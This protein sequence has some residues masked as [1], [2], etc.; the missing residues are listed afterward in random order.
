MENIA[1]IQIVEPQPERRTAVAAAYRRGYADA[2]EDM[3]KRQREK[4]RRRQYFIMQK[5]NGMSNVYIRSQNR[6]KLYIFGISF[7]SL[8]YEE[9]HDYKRGKEAATHHTICIADGCL[10]EI[11]EYES[12]ERCIEVLDEIEKVCG[13]YL[14]A[15]GSMGLIRGSTPMQPMATVIP[16]VYQMPEK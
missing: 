15:A 6:E 11:A 12:K 10:E 8:Q 4:K 2:L 13:S 7:N 1:R 14:Y 5:L 3:R 9:Q 16:R